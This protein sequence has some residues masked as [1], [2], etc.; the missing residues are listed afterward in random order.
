M[1]RSRLGHALL[2]ALLFGLPS[3]R[4]SAAPAQPD[5]EV[6]LSRDAPTASLVASGRRVFLVRLDRDIRAVRFEVLPLAEKEDAGRWDVRLLMLAPSRDPDPVD[7]GRA[8]HGTLLWKASGVVNP[9]HPMSKDTPSFVPRS[10]YRNYAVILDPSE[11]GRITDENA[12]MFYKANP[13]PD[14]KYL[15][16]E[17]TRVPRF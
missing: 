8:M 13:L 2:V 5:L 12:G 3:G 1:L 6:A 14:G 4:A 11:G 17:G 15:H 9:D 16:F 10:D 7:V